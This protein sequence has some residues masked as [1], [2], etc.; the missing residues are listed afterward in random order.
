MRSESKTLVAACNL[1]VHGDALLLVQEAKPSAGG[2]YS[3]PAGK[4]EPGE[5]II[6]AAVR[7]AHEE[8]G[9]RVEVVALVGIYHCPETSEGTAVVN[10]VFESRV[11]GGAVA[12]TQAH[13][14]VRFVPFGEV[15]EL[16]VAQLLRGAHVLVGCTR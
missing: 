16:A 9:L 6:E 14:E 5:T 3:L 8:T 7:E 1:I 15:E 10:H 2:R 13:P 11:L 12:P 4:V